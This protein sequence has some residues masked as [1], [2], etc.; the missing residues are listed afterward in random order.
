MAERTILSVQTCLKSILKICVRFTACFKTVKDIKK[1][2]IRR[3]TRWAWRLLCIT[4]APFLIQGM[5]WE[6]SWI[7]SLAGTCCA[8]CRSSKKRSCP[9]PTAHRQTPVYIAPMLKTKPPLARRSGAKSRRRRCALTGGESQR[10][11][12][13]WYMMAKKIKLSQTVMILQ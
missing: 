8:T 10:R 2:F 5:M 4:S 6:N 7:S 9:A 1:T 12:S 3:K 11:T 13:L